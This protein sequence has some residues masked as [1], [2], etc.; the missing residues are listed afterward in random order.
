MYD[1]CEFYDA[2]YDNGKIVEA[3]Y[4]EN[5]GTVDYSRYIFTRHDKNDNWLE[6]SVYKN[7]EVNPLYTILREIEYY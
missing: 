3:K 5:F 2:I 6:A 1:N 4:K 7:N